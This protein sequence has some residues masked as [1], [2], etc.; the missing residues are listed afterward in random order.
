MS[1]QSTGFMWIV[2]ICAAL[3]AWLLDPW[4]KD[5]IQQSGPAL[6]FEPSE[7]QID[8]VD[9]LVVSRQGESRLVFQRTDDGWKQVEPFEVTA[10]GF[11][12][13]QLLVAAADLEYSRRVPVS[14][15]GPESSLEQL[16]L[17][18]PLATLKITLGDRTEQ[19]ELGRRTVAGRGWMRRGADGDLIVVQDELH[20]LG[21]E[22]DLRNWR[23]G[24]LFPGSEE[25][26]SIEIQNGDLLTQLNRDGQL[27][28]ME[29]PVQTRAEEESLQRIL[30]VLGRVEHTGF[31]VDMPDDLSVFGLDDPPVRLKVTR[32]ENSQTLLLGS[33]SGL[34]SNDRYAMIEGVP[35]VVRVDE[36]ILRALLPEVTSLIAQTA[37][38]IR[39]AD[40]KSIEV[41]DR[42]GGSVRLERNL[43]RWFI[44]QRMPNG[45][46]AAGVTDA[47]LVEE[48]LTTLTQLRAS[49]VA[50]QKFPDDLSHANVTFFGYDGSPLDTVRVA[51]E[52]GNGRWAIENGDGVL[53]I[54]PDSTKLPIKAGAWQ[55][56]DQLP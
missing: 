4:G 45:E 30:S 17:A 23:S 53:R 22:A 49:E 34:V 38:G 6:V 9:E 8:Q 21:A 15:L 54:F 50:V 14:E 33:P 40:I 1:W 13:R 11:A 24:L 55:V 20:I 2:A 18:P 36:P 10:D 46:E 7:F 29:S 25:I 42:D 28:T 43:D 3:G 16:G 39:S 41:V 27:W 19:I 52:L 56:Q 32:G 44:E 5:N 26:D 37:S 35:T 12:V 51:R 47:T 48:F 31:V